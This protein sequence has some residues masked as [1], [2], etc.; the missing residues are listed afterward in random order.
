MG[1]RNVMTNR[2][3]FVS[4]SDHIHI[5]GLTRHRVAAATSWLGYSAQNK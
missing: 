1:A 3:M 5:G 2:G 4:V